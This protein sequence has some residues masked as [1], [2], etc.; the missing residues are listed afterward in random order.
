MEESRQASVELIGTADHTGC[1]VQHL[2][3]FVSCRFRRTRQDCVAVVNA[4]RDER[5]YECGRWLRVEWTPNA[6]VGKPSAVCQPTK[7]TQPLILSGS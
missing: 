5:M 6:Y 3:Q 1:G 2:L 4:R 7:P